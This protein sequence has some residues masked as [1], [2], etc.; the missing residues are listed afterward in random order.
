MHDGEFFWRCWRKLTILSLI[1]AGEAIIVYRFEQFPIKA[2]G[3]WSWHFT[4]YVPNHISTDVKRRTNGNKPSLS[5]SFLTTKFFACQ[6]CFQA[7]YIL[8]PFCLYTQTI[9]LD[10]KFESKIKLTKILLTSWTSLI[11]SPCSTSPMWL[12]AISKDK[13]GLISRPFL[14]KRSIFHLL[15]Y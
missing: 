10:T 11:L 5:T 14:A 1:G 3:K 2:S 9:Q 4:S 6:P 12:L 7:W 13:Q 8:G 15:F